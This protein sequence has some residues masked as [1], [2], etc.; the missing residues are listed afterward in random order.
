M[1]SHTL[2]RLCAH[3]HRRTHIHT[4][5]LTHLHTHT[6]THT[7]TWALSHTLSLYHIDTHTHIYWH[8][9]TYLHPLKL[10]DTR[11]FLMK[12]LLPLLWCWC[13]LLPMDHRCRTLPKTVWYVMYQC[14]SPF[15]IFLLLSFLFLTFSPFLI[16][17]IFINH[18]VTYIEITHTH[19]LGLL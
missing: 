2:T 3:T 17:S 5:T 6:Y 8:S 4:E 16:P 15:F 1:R 19:L 14:W 10:T 11:C 18:Q 13:L 9:C 7:H 12:S